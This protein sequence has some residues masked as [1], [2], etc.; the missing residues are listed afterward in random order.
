[1]EFSNF[2]VLGEPDSFEVA[3]TLF[4]I[5][6]EAL[7]YITEDGAKVTLNVGLKIGVRNLQCSN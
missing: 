6:L 1:M 5:F 7:L 3:W 2:R 4:S